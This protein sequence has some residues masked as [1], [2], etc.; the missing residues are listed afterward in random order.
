M[1]AHF[2]ASVTDLEDKIVGYRKIV[3]ILS[4]NGVKLTNEWIETAYE[5]MQIGDD[6]ENIESLWPKIYKEN[7]EAVSRADVIVAE[8][9]NRSFLVGFQVAYALQM[10][11]PILLL[12]NHSNTKGA[13]GL[14]SNEEIIK[15]SRYDATNIEAIVTNF[16][17]ENTTSSK[18]LRFNFFIDRKILNYL[19]WVSFQTGETKSEIIRNILTKEINK[20]DF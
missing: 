16:I 20:S 17:K 4:K 18:D 8:I 2:I 10:K 13:I 14:S 11:K 1:K 15:F 12:S 7:R 3:Q 5:R 19:N 6:A 9:S